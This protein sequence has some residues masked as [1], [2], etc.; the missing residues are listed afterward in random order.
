PTH[1]PPPRTHSPQTH[2]PPRSLTLSHPQTRCPS[3]RY[4]Q[5]HCLSLHL[6]LKLRYHHQNHLTSRLVE[7]QTRLEN[8]SHELLPM[9]G[10]RNR[11]PIGRLLLAL[12]A[13]ETAWLQ[14]SSPQ[15]EWESLSE[16]LPTGCST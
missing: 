3:R 11:S 1:P 10:N 16:R 4:P 14:S 7:E 6:S 5:S 8:F 9:L 13:C 12:D 2:L 15:Q